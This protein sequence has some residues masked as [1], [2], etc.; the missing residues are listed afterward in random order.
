MP[1]EKSKESH[2]EKIKD[3]KL[4]ELKTKLS[5]IKTKIDDFQKALIKK[6]DKYIL[7]IALLPP[8]KD[9]KSK[10]ALDILVVVDD[11]DSKKM[12]KLELKD[13]LIAIST[14]IGKDIDKNITVEVVL[15]SEMRQNCFDNKFEFLQDIAISA[16]VYDPQDLIAALKVSEVHKNMVMKKF[17]KYITSYVAAGSLFRGEKSNDIDVYVIVDDTDVKKM[18]RFELKEKLR[19][20]ILS[21][22]FEASAITRVKKKF[23]VQVYI[24]TDF[25]EGLK[26]ANP[27]FFTLLRDGIPLYDRGVFMPWKLLLEMGRIKPSPEA[28]DMFVASG[29]KMANKV[30]F[31]LREIIEA[32][33]Y[34]SVLTPT[35]AALMMYGVAPPT[36][37]ETVKIMN[38]VFVKKEK[39]LEKKYVDMLEEIR[40]YYK[41]LE[42][43]KITQVTGKD[44]DRMTNNATIYLKRL[45][46]LFKQIEQRKEQETLKEIYETLEV[47]VKDVLS[48]NELDDKNLELG[49]K[50]V[51]EK[52]EISS[53]TLKEYRDIMKTKKEKLNKVEFYKIRREA[54]LLTVKLMDYVQRK[55][56]KELQKAALRVKYEDKF[57]EVIVLDN[58]VYIIKDLSNSS[59]ISKANLSKT[60]EITSVEKSSIKEFEDNLTKKKVPKSVFIKNKTIESLK[61][62]F[63]PDVEVLVNY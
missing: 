4:D 6:F 2:L 27:V 29:D 9:E 25:W 50:K 34:W 30:R 13:R 55:K 62:I 10:D 39:L 1:K 24:L 8:R 31:R 58:K 46:K 18:S 51:Q 3:D 60:G 63:G 56:G 59:E 42:H 5:K 16:P 20:I 57:G 36:P 28:I 15:L 43:D 37:K 33:I 49:L 32:D 47:L 48:I 54:K 61:E 38:D 53:K 11:N 12:P 14:N 7:G 40:T 19:A 45:K 41:D 35:Q 44:V 23:H 52:N 26:D 22:A 17:E 21:Q